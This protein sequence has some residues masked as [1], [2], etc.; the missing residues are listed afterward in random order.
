MKVAEVCSRPSSLQ[1]QSSE[2]SSRKEFD[3]KVLGYDRTM[4]TE[5]ANRRQSKGESSHGLSFFSL[6]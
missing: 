4:Q 1:C 6:K 2:T 5:S 3:F